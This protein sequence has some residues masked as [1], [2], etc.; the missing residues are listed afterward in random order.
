MN[1]DDLLPDFDDFDRITHEAA[2]VKAELIVIKSQLAQLEAQCM[3]NALTISDN[4]IGG[5]RPSMSYCEKIVKEIGNNEQE[6]DMLIDLRRQLADKTEALQLLQYLITVNR[7]KL[8]L[9]QTLSANNRKGF[10]T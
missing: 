7:E 3:H 9:F 6:R 5:K 10:L 1:S 8:D 4:W 2:K